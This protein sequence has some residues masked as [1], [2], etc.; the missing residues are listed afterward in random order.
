MT[1]DTSVTND[2]EC[3]NIMADSEA[4]NL[5]SSGDTMEASSITNGVE[6]RSN[7]AETPCL[8]P[9]LIRFV[10]AA[11]LVKGEDVPVSLVHVES[12]RRVWVSRT[13]DESRVSSIMDKLATIRDNLQSAMRLKKGAIYGAVWHQDGEMYR[14]VIK[15]IAEE[16]LHVQFIDFG[17]EEKILRCEALD[18]PEDLGKEAAGALLV[19]LNHDLEESTETCALLEE[20]MALRV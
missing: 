19:E 18:I 4:I 15:N 17:N 14:I 9:K 10:P 8:K 16:E 3:Q 1:W 20:L 2:G 6:N 13:E 7:V 11:P 12:S 5:K